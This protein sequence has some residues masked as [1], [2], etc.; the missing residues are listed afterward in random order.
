MKKKEKEIHAGKKRGREREKH[1]G[2]DLT[3]RWEMRLTEPDG[4]HE[5]GGSLSISSSGR[6]PR[7]HQYDARMPSRFNEPERPP[8]ISTLFLRL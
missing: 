8:R 2:N 4:R 6:T 1:Q 3:G 5:A 7:K